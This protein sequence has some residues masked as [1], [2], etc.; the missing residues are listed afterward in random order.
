MIKPLQGWRLL[1]RLLTGLLLL[2]LAPA[3]WAET[4]LRGGLELGRE[5]KGRANL[6][7]LNLATPVWR[8][9]FA[10]QGFATRLHAEGSAGRYFADSGG[11]GI[12]E[13]GLRGFTRTTLGRNGPFFA[14]IGTGLIAI[15]K[16]RLNGDAWG[17]GIQFRSHAGLGFWLGQQQEGA[18]ILRLSHSSN[19]SRETP[20]PGIDVASLMLEW[21][22]L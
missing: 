2:T 6:I 8:T 16:R 13:V 3:A 10:D 11:G 15:D 4:E 17:S 12:W 7:R 18:V 21:R 22:F 20:N 5:W 1:R 14:E 9:F 19:G